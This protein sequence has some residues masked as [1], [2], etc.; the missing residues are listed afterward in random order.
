MTKELGEKLRKAISFAVPALKKISDEDASGRPFPGKW[1]KKEILGHLIDSAGNNQQKFVRMMAQ[2]HL[3]F[4]GYQQNHWVDSQKYVGTDWPELVNFWNSFN[5]HLAHI[6]ENADAEKL[7]NTIIIED[8]GP[9][10]LEF[11]MTDYLE[12]LKHH[13]KQILPDADL[14]SNFDNVYK[15]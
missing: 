9:F 11:V 7:S 14:E 4:V 13:L 1:S 10:T 5:L 3:D 8:A 15:A 2:K 6:I 12:H